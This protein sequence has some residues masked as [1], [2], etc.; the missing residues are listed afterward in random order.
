MFLHSMCSW[1]MYYE[2]QFSSVWI[3]CLIDTKNS[4]FFIKMLFPLRLPIIRVISRRRIILYYLGLAAVQKSGEGNPFQAY[5]GEDV[6][7]K[8]NQDC[9][10]CLEKAITQVIRIFCRWR[11]SRSRPV[12]IWDCARLCASRKLYQILGRAFLERH[13]F[14]PFC[15]GGGP[16]Q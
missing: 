6:S 11:C 4:M 12:T 9:Q 10:Q 1:S 14:I 2:T 8:V 3:F 7:E 5:L 15:C 16:L 13:L